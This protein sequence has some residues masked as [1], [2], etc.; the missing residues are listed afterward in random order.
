MENPIKLKEIG[1]DED[2]LAG[3]NKN[4]NRKM[5]IEKNFSLEGYYTQEEDCCDT[6]KEGVQELFLNHHDGGG[7]IFYTLSSKR[8]AFETPEELTSIINEFI[9][10]IKEL[11]EKI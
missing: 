10:K 6:S 9:K 1:F 7:G 11:N 8:W 2:C 4:N 3:Y 5:D